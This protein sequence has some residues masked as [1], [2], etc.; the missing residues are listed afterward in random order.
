MFNAPTGVTLS[1]ALLNENI[2]NV[3]DD[4]KNLPKDEALVLLRQL[5]KQE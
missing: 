1:P 2:E 5:M 3:K 4:L